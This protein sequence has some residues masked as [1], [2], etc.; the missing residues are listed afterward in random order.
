MTEQMENKRIAF[1]GLTE[2]FRIAE[3]A[4]GSLDQYLKTRLGLS[5]ERREILREKYLI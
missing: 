5:D 2:A 4:A 3:E 1:E